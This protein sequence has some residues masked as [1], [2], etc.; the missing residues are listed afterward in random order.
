M[1]FPYL[2]FSDLIIE[3][4]ISGFLCGNLRLSTCHDIVYCFLSIILLTTHASYGLTMSPKSFIR[5]EVMSSKNSFEASTVPYKALNASL[6]IVGI[7]FFPSCT[8][9]C[10]H[11]GFILSRDLNIAPY[12]L[13]IIPSLALVCKNTTDM[14]IAAMSRSSCASMNMDSIHTVG[15]SFFF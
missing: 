2:S 1:M 13:M 14:A 9:N 10:F 7:L 5:K 11:V 4:I 8:M 3:I 12:S 15:D 6:Y